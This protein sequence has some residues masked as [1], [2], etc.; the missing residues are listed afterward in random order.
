MCGGYSDTKCGN[1]GFI[2]LWA[3]LPPKKLCVYCNDKLEFIDLGIGISHFGLDPSQVETIPKFRANE[4][5]YVLVESLRNLALSKQQQ[6]S[7]LPADFERSPRCVRTSVQL[8][9]ELCFRRVPW[10]YPGRITMAYLSPLV[11]TRILILAGRWILHKIVHTGTFA[12]I[13]VWRV[14]SAWTHTY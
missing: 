5:N 14:S 11:A 9:T 13:I 7:I 6:G 4:T 1:Y 12:V 10:K 3:S 8:A 2:L